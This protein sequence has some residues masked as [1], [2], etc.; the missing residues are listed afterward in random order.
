MFDYVFK[1]LVIVYLVGWGALTLFAGLIGNNL[2]DSLKFG[3]PW[4]LVV[5]V[6]YTVMD[7]LHYRY[8]LAKSRRQ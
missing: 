3:A 6:I 1:R 8:Y 7:Y 2:P 5:V 4:A